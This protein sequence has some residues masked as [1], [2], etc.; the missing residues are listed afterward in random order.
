M[1]TTESF[2][3]SHT[4]LDTNRDFVVAPFTT[5]GPANPTDAALDV[6][7]VA[8]QTSLIFYGKGSPNYGDRIQENILHVME[9]FAG[10]NEPV[11]PVPGQMWFDR[12]TTPTYSWVGIADKPVLRVFDPL[13]HEIVAVDVG[14]NKI[15]ISGNH[16]ELPGGSGPTGR[17]KSGMVLRIF[18]NPTTS[19][20]ERLFSATGV[21]YNTS[22]DRTDITLSGTIDLTFVGRF[23]GE[24]IQVNT[25]TVPIPPTGLDAGGNPIINV[26]T[27]VNPLDAVNKNYVDTQIV[28]VGDTN[29]VNVIGDT[30]T[31]FLTLNADPIAP[32]HAATMQ[33]VD[34]VITNHDAEHDD[35][36]V[37]LSGDVMTGSLILSGDPTVALQAATKQY[38]DGQTYTLGQLVDVDTAAQTPGDI[39]VFNGVDWTVASD[40]TEAGILFLSGGTM[41]GDLILNAHPTVNFQAA[42]KQY[43]DDEITAAVGGGGTADGVV[44]GGS[45]N[46]TTADLTLNRSLGLPDII[47]PG[48]ASSAGGTQDDAV[49]NHTIGLDRVQ[50]CGNLF[51]DN[52]STMPA[53]RQLNVRNVLE[54]LGKSLGAFTCPVGYDIASGRNPNKIAQDELIREAN[55]FYRVG[56]NRLMVFVD[57]IKQQPRKHNYAR[58][59]NLAGSERIFPNTPVAFTADPAPGTVFLDF[60][61]SFDTLR[62]AALGGPGF[63]GTISIDQSSL[64]TPTWQELVDQINAQIA[65]AGVAIFAHG[66]VWITSNQTDF[67]NRVEINDIA[68]GADPLWADINAEGGPTYTLPI[69]FAD[70]I[71]KTITVQGDIAPFIGRSVTTTTQGDDLVVAGTTW[72][73]DNTYVA[74]LVQLPFYDPQTNQ[75][76]IK[77]DVGNGP[78]LLASY[79]GGVGDGTLSVSPLPITIEVNFDINRKIFAWVGGYEEGDGTNVVGDVTN[80]VRFFGSNLP[81]SEAVI[82]FIMLDDPAR[83]N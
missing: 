68:P 31:G 59:V 55:F 54:D 82:E 1:A 56:Y 5:N 53:E 76:V 19:T 44:T 49:I 18:D 24:W 22:L 47:I 70:N 51:T 28:T 48:V 3:I 74:S 61:I 13:F 67:Y 43:V 8:A 81:P 46:A 72:G 11:Y 36:F 42:T 33:Y 62:P 12:R 65:G 66:E 80:Q 20:E 63:S 16:T 29:Y 39:L 37:N 83:D 79:T 6:N 45:Y 50:G 26:P 32:L 69:L 4:D 2:L 78:D 41:T 25:A 21:T 27:P 14:L 64:V 10:V 9:S 60:D 71:E 52:Q 38:V 77:L 57:G 7:A 58:I 17:F 73:G 35:R 75:T 40:S 34:N 30:M 23:L 15:S